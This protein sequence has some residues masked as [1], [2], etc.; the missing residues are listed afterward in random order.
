MYRLYHRRIRHF[1]DAAQLEKPLRH[2]FDLPPSN[3][4]GCP[5]N[6][7]RQEV[8]RRSPEPIPSGS[9]A[10]RDFSSY[11]G[12][13]LPKKRV[14]DAL[15]GPG[16]AL[17]GSFTSH[18]WCRSSRQLIQQRLRLLEVRRVEPFG[19]PAVDRREEIAASVRLPWSR[20]RRARLV[21]A[22]NSSALAT[23]LR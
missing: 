22:R 20:Q 12:F 3:S 21:E 16:A 19:E 4:K 6:P 9:P 23:C 17:V 10:Y 5:A 18:R 8:P 11:K 15:L 14:R 1:G 13:P 2:D 7:G